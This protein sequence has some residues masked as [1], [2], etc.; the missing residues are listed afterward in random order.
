MATMTRKIGTALQAMH[1]FSFLM[2]GVDA[3]VRRVGKL[4]LQDIFGFHCIAIYHQL[5]V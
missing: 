5:I 1:V 4:V 3:V 2:E